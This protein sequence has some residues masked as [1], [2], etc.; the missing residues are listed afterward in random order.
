LA[1]AQGGEDR[2]LEERG[3]AFL[4]DQDRLLVPREGND[5]LGDERVGDI[6]AVDGD[7]RG[8]ERVGLAEELQRAD[9]SVVH[10]ALADDPQVGPLAIEELVEAVFLHESDGGGPA[11]VDLVLLLRVGRRRQADAAVVEVGVLQQVLLRDRRGAVR[12]GAERALHVAGADAHLEHHRRARGLGELERLLDHLDQLRQV[13]ARVEQPDLRLH[14][15]GVAALLDDRGAL[16]VVLAEHDQRAALHAGR[17]DVGQ[18]VGGDVGADGGLERDRAAHRVIDRRAEH[19]G[20]AGLVGVRLDVDAELV[21]DLA[22][23]VQ[24]IHHVRHRRALVAADIG[25]AR[26]QERFGHRENAFAV[27]DLA[28]P[29]LQLADFFLERAFHG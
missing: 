3:L 17:G 19:R 11:H 29:Q 6:E 28:V 27:E 20:G 9:D 25:D 22:R 18:R 26:L 14:G 13:G 16:A 23:V 8:A 2:V 10:A 15:E 24:H 21:E 1:S 5:L 12:L 7:L 4:D